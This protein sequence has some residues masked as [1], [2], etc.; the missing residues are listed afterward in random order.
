MQ[1]IQVEGGEGKILPRFCLL[2][3]AGATYLKL[4]SAARFLKFCK[5]RKFPGWGGAEI[6]NTLKNMQLLSFQ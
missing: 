3:L 4:N 1:P 5:V 2:R 6:E